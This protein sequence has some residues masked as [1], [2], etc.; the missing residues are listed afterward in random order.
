[1]FKLDKK[2]LT[3]L[4]GLGVGSAGAAYVQQKFLVKRNEDGSPKVDAEGN[5][6]TL[7]GAGTTANMIVDIAPAVI[8]LALQGQGSFLKEAGKG[9]IAASIGGLIK[10]QVPDLGITGMDTLLGQVPVVEPTGS[11]DRP[12]MGYSSNST[13]FTSGDSGE[14]D[15]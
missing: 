3:E 9:M 14:M 4:A 2:T 5:P 10:K 12:L 13:D 1:M 15:F 7:F 6:E 11:S 8:G